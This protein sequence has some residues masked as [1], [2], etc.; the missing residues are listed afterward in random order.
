MDVDEF[1][2]ILQ[3]ESPKL[4]EFFGLAKTKEEKPWLFSVYSGFILPLVIGIVIS[5]YKIPIDF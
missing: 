3:E 4:V 5:H 2:K 1:S